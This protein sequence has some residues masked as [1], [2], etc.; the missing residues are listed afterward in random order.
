MGVVL[1]PNSIRCCPPTPRPSTQAAHQFLFMACPESS[2]SCF[3][4]LVGFFGY[5]LGL[6]NCASNG[7]LSSSELSSVL[8]GQC[9]ATLVS[10]L[11]RIVHML[12]SVDFTSV[13]NWKLKMFSSMFSGMSCFLPYQ[14]T[15]LSMPPS[16]RTPVRFELSIKCFS[17]SSGTNASRPASLISRHVVFPL[18]DLRWKF[19]MRA[20]S[21][22]MIVLKS[23]V[24]FHLSSD[25]NVSAVFAMPPTGSSASWRQCHVPHNS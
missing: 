25:H 14:F 24:S 15:N 5:L 22:R 3:S 9:S 16:N 12:V 21:K 17:S 19:Q 20:P 1:P 11:L 8:R 6:G 13:L 10:R 4:R 7:S 2:C 23:F 18:L